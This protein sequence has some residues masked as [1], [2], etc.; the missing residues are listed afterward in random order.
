M[1]RSSLLATLAATVFA[2]AAAA[3][4][5]SI[6]E[7]SDGATVS[8][9]VKVRFAVQGATVGPAGEVIANTGH[10]HLLI[11]TGPIPAGEVIPSDATHLHFGGGQTEVEVPLP[12]GVHKLT[13][14]FADGKHNSYGPAM[15]QT[16]T[17]TVK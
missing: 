11:D 9:P 15:S 2:G 17:V 3:A 13:A 12:P 7:P 4:S 6:V 10:H 14:Q 8:S 5:I 16:I 1:L